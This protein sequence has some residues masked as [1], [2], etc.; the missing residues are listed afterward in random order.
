[1]AVGAI[2]LAAVGLVLLSSGGPG[3]G[4]SPVPTPTPIVMAQGELAPLVPGTH[5]TADFLV[6]VT[7]TVPD[8]WEGNVGGP[9][10]VDLGQVG[11]QQALAVSVFDTVYADPCD[12]N[13]GPID[14]PPGP[15]V[16][17]LV[18][19]LVGLPSLVVSTPTD[20]TIDG[21]RGK[22]LTLTAPSSLSGC[23]LSPDSD[24]RIWALPLG[25]THGMNPGYIS[26]LWILDVDGQR[27]VID[28]AEWPG[29]TAATK[30]EIQ[31][32]LDSIQLEPA[33]PTASPS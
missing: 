5:V 3:P 29:Q 4:P 33:Q 20:V 15:S 21:Y 1:V 30:A 6:P 8:G 22:Q 17:D 31:G 13:K 10:L 2:A 16:D 11:F 32:V 19:A 7:F 26:H 27:V 18:T 24:L 28:T 12:F 23:T 9:Y 25:A 14:P